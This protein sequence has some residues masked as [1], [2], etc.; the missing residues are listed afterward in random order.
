MT[1][2]CLFTT[3]SDITQHNVNIL[4]HDVKIKL[5][6]T[7]VAVMLVVLILVLVVLKCL[8]LLKNFTF[9]PVRLAAPLLIVFT[10]KPA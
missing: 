5:I 2:L 1:F 9:S 10:V 8:I 6:R 4:Y 3:L 7:K